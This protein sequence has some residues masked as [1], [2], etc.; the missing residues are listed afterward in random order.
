[1]QHLKPRFSI[2]TLLVCIALVAMLLAAGIRFGAHFVW[3][4]ASSRLR[5]V[6]SI[7]TATLVVPPIVEKFGRCEIGPISLDL[8]M[9][10]HESFKVQRDPRNGS[11]NLRFTD[12][13]RTV[14]VNL[15][16]IRDF[17]MFPLTGFPD[18][19]DHT[20]SQ[21]YRQIATVKSSDF[22]FGM[23]AEELRWHEW[24]VTNRQFMP[25]V[26]SIE[27]VDKPE[28]EGNLL[29]FAPPTGIAYNFEWATTDGE[30]NG[31]VTFHDQ[32]DNPDWIRFAASTFAVSGDPSVFQNATDSEIES[33]IRS[34]ASS[35]QGRQ[36]SHAS[37]D[38]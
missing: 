22:S 34:F 32:T 12:S 18:K 16:P 27:H 33:V 30:W 15:T 9:S 5:S 1:M 13:A 24:L 4:A 36:L 29:R 21:L 26:E 20:H 35:K 23:T 17:A 19:T 28:F 25:D 6:E 7:P 11:V 37:A 8:P 3:L 31:A 10:M 38:N 14:L 2:R